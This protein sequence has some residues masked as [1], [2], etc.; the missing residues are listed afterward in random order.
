MS[1]D[2]FIKDEQE[3]NKES[4]EIINNLKDKYSN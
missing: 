2:N 1:M 4:M 3:K